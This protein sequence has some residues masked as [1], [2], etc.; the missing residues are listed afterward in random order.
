M[1]IEPSEATIV[2][3][4]Q[5]MV[6][7]SPKDHKGDADMDHRVLVRSGQA[8]RIDLSGITSEIL[9]SEHTFA[10][11]D[12]LEIS[13]DY[14]RWRERSEIR[15]RD[16]DLVAY[17]TFEESD[18]TGD[19]SGLLHNKASGSRGSFDGRLG[20]GVDP[21]TR[22]RWTV[23]RWPHKGALRLDTSLQQRVFVG[24]WSKAGIDREITVAA[25]FRPMGDQ[26]SRTL[27]SVWSQNSE[28]FHFSTRER[29]LALR[30]SNDG[31]PGHGL[32]FLQAADGKPIAR[33]EGWVHV[34][35]T[36]IAGGGPVRLYKNGES[37]DLGGATYTP[38]ALPRS[39]E[40]LMIGGKSGGGSGFTGLIDELSIY[41][42]ALSAKEIA[43]LA[44]VG[45]PNG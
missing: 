8:L 4:T 25:W 23:G 12:E 21:S 11:A 40:P 36:L 38:S 2:R 1:R 26:S 24:D 18:A 39:I 3:V 27:V 15:R 19:Q 9:S 34:A 45:K 29:G 22:P 43:R 30:L 28:V 32:A 7:A 31:I 6:E 20:N 42:R 16:P 14:R 5:G 10:Y 41:R 37:I 33:R 17:Y 44:E 35:F 13:D